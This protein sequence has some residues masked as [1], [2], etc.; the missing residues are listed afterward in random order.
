[1]ARTKLES[2]Y[3]LLVL[4]TVPLICLSCG[5][6]NGEAAPYPD[7]NFNASEWK[8]DSTGC[9]TYR[10]RACVSITKNEGFFRGKSY[11]FL[12]NFLGPPTFLYQ[13]VHPRNSLSY[14]VECTEVPMQ[15]TGVR[16]KA[17]YS[18][19]PKFSAANAAT[20]VFY[21]RGDTCTSVGIVEP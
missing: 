17:K 18:H 4:C 12:L 3:C 16:D 8:K 7:R 2:I 14:V 21:M 5:T 15:L 1:M 6:H 9:T 20:L 19:K 11:D 10:E 13:G